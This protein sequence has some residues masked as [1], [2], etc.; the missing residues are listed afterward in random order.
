VSEN[1]PLARRMPGFDA[2]H[3]TQR[4]RRGRMAA[5][6]VVILV[7]AAVVYFVVGRGTSGPPP[8]AHRH[9]PPTA[10]VAK[11]DSTLAP[12]R[13]GAPISRAVVVA[14]ATSGGNQLVIIGG[15][16]T[17]GLTASGAFDLDVT[18]G[19][20]TQVGDLTSTLDDA[21]GAVLN[22]QDVVFGGASSTAPS[23][24]TTASVQALSATAPAPATGAA[25]PTSALLGT[26]PQ[27]RAGATT[28]SVGTT[29]YLVGGENS[30][31]ADPAILATSDGRHFT[32]AATLP[33]PV[34]FPA[35]AAVGGKLYVFG[36]DATAG[37]EA[38]NA[39]DTIQVVDLHTH[40]VT[41]SEHL[42]EALAG[43]AAVVLG[44]D[45]L[46][47]GGDTAPSTTGATTTTAAGATT[48]PAPSSVS[49]VWS[50]DP[51]SG[52]STSVGQL[53]VAV[54]HAGL[55][56]LGSTAWLVGGES[57]GTPVSTVQSF[58]TVPSSTGPASTAA[59]A[60]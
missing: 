15:A 9:T 7:V 21:A 54:S 35:V 19:A 3:A 34:L 33:V 46:V 2:R 17:G 42:P 11:V 44:H 24:S 27:P 51:A 4:A 50:F 56:V 28:V 12:W 58:V 26:L 18:D 36:G 10:A 23:A 22:G 52:H 59:T 6:V 1:P 5:A 48:G 38:G 25:E 39:V 13:L 45:V 37:P 60:T 53:P 49:T 32:V 43:A 41:D 29:T 47:A 55:A 31:G 8:V 14:G 30:V 20:L 57:D 16:T 40:K